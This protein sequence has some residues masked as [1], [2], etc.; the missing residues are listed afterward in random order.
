MPY[1]TSSKYENFAGLYCHTETLSSRQNCR[2]HRCDFE[3]TSDEVAQF[4]ALDE[5]TVSFR[6][7]IHLDDSNYFVSLGD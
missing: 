6:N 4:D 2:K 3:L 1:D 5:C 7:V